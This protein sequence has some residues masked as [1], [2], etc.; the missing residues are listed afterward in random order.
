MD[1]RHV[2]DFQSVQF[3]R[4]A[5]VGKF[6]ATQNHPGFRIQNTD[7][8]DTGHGQRRDQRRA[9]QKHSPRQHRVQRGIHW[10]RG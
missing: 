8:I 9:R 7:R 6:K 2:G 3:R 5:G 10:L 4:Q 1:I